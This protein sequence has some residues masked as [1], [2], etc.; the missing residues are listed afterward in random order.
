M[1]SNSV[2]KLHQQHKMHLMVCHIIKKNVI[3]ANHS[4]LVMLF[5][6]A[7]L[8]TSLTLLIHFWRFFFDLTNC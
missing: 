8:Y 1:L 6:T 5:F 2:Q 7:H 3:S 4:G